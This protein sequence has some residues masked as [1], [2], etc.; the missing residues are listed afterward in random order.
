MRPPFR[1]HWGST[2][3]DGDDG[4]FEPKEHWAEWVRSE[5]RVTLHPDLRRKKN[6]DL[7][8]NTL[9]HEFVH[10]VYN[11]GHSTPANERRA[12]RLEERA[13]QALHDFFHRFLRGGLPRCTGEH[14]HA[15]PKKR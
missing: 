12:N 2:D 14:C 1:W 7:L 8:W 6:H 5:R 11:D 15:G 9:G 3:A 10:Q 4:V 13:G